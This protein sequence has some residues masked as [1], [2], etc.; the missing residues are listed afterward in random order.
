[1]AK[2]VV[3]FKIHWLLLYTVPLGVTELQVLSVEGI[4]CVF[5]CVSKIAKSDYLPSSYPSV[6]RSVRVEQLGFHRTAL[7]ETWYLSFSRN[8]V[9]KIKVSLKSDENNGCF[10][11]Y[12]MSL[13]S[14]QNEKWFRQKL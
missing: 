9:E 13:N 12:D 8:A 6:R 10:H 7:N 1:M 11:I 3:P 2:C 14:F 4:F 5:M